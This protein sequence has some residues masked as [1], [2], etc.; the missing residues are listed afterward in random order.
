MQT[1]RYPAFILLLL[2]CVI[3][4]MRQECRC[5]DVRWRGMNKLLNNY[6]RET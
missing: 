5:L 1:V 6:K 3:A 4:W 2:S